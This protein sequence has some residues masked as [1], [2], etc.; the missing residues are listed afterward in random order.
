MTSQSIR[1]KPEEWDERMTEVIDLIV[2]LHY[3]VKDLAEHFNCHKDAVIS[4]LNRR[5]LSV[6]RLRHDYAN[7]KDVYS[8]R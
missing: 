7:G 1:I 2:H 8:W 5:G 6:I 3:R 4:A